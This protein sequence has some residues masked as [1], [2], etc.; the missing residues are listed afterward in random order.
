[1]L[2]KFQMRTRTL[3]EAG[4]QVMHFICWQGICGFFSCPRNLN[5]AEF[6]KQWTPFLGR[7]TFVRA[8]CAGC[9]VV[10]AYCVYT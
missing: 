4:L 7:G 1:M 5:K 10:V 3:L 8:E 9:G 6:R 2:I